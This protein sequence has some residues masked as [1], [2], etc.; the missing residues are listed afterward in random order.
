MI[1]L[2]FI[3]PNQFKPLYEYPRVFVPCPP[4]TH[5]YPSVDNPLTELVK[6]ELALVAALKTKVSSEYIKRFVPVPPTNHLSAVI[7]GAVDDGVGVTVGVIVGV[8]VGVK[9][10]VGEGEGSG[11][12]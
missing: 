3:E 4:P 9:L 8:I 7:I 6:I 11:T 2:P 10:G 1:L 5:I 12:P